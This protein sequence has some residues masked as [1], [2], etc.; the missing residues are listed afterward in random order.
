[1]NISLS[2]ENN[3]KLY[4]DGEYDILQNIKKYFTKYVPGY[5]YHPKYKAGVWNGKICLLDISKREL[6]YRIIIWFIKI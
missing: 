5:I 1:M 3:L 6:P 2:N 4:L